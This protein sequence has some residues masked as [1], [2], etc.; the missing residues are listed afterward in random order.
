MHVTLNSH[1][2]NSIVGV[3]ALSNGMSLANVTHAR[4]IGV[5]TSFSVEPT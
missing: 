2:L 5:F 3:D 4:A 1:I